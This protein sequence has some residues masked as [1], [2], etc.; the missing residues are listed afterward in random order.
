MPEQLVPMVQP[1][2]VGAQQLARAFDQVGVRGF[3]HQMKM[4]LH[5]AIGM[6]LPTRL[7]ARFGESLEEILPVYIVMSSRRSPRLMRW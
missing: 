2:G 5:Q 6:D 1:D 3:G 7:L 4:I